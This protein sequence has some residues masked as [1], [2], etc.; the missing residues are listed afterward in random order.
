MTGRAVP[1]VD[2]VVIDDA[3]GHPGPRAMQLALGVVALLAVLLLTALA[4]QMRRPSTGLVVGR[5]APDFT[6]QTY[7]GDMIRLSEL[8]GNVVVLNFWASWCISCVYEAAELERLSQEYADEGV[9]FLGVAYTDTEP[10]ALAYLERH[11]VTYPNGPD[12]GG[13]ISQR[14][15]LLG[16]PETIV[17]DQLGI[18]VGLSVRGE[19]V[20]QAKITGPI[21]IK[22]TFTPDDMRDLLDALT[23]GAGA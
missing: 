9:V 18:V 14:Y 4:M 20:P 21:T 23:Q 13:A 15:R 12:R 7:D 1:D 17:I 2:D 5:P 8:Q 6:L 10:A 19:D 11:G 16:V 3:R 22:A